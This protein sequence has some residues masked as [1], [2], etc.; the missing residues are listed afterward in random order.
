[1]RTEFYL[2][3]ARLRALADLIE[4]ETDEGDDASTLNIYSE[5]ED[6]EVARWGLS[7]RHR[8]EGNGYSFR[9][10]GNWA[11]DIIQITVK[12]SR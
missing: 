10:T 2:V 9:A 1:M 7:V 11:N 12:V 5:D 8:R 3:A 4:A 6:G